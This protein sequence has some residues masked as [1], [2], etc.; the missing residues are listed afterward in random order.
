LSPGPGLSIDITGEPVT[1]ATGGPTGGGYGNGGS[2]GQ[3][4]DGTSGHAGVVIVAYQ[5]GPIPPRDLVLEFDT[6]LGDRTIEM[7]LQGTVDAV[8]DWGD[9]TITEH[10]GA[11]VYEHTYDVDGIYTVRVSGTATQFGASKGNDGEDLK[12]PELVR[13]L[14][15]GEIG[16]T[17]LYCAFR[18][19]ENVTTVPAQLPITSTITDMRYIF[20][21][22]YVFNQDISG[23]DVSRVTD[24]GGMFENAHVFNQDLSGWDVSRVTDMGGMFANAYVFNQDLSGWCVENIPTEPTNFAKGADAWTQPKP[25]WGTCP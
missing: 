12:R 10:Q 5:V 9:G 2:G 19:C 7:P 1:Y 17:S 20:E 23:W 22:A 4:S 24:M 3:G 8:I 21:Y 25:I 14:S 15:F 13:C 16:L 18:Y 6:T 11:G